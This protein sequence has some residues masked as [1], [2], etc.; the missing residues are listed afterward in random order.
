MK[1][2]SQIAEKAKEALDTEVEPAIK[3]PEK[4]ADKLP[5]RIAE[6]SEKAIGLF[7]GGFM[8]MGL[9]VGGVIGFAASGGSEH[10]FTGGW[11]D[12]VMGVV[13][14]G[15]FGL[16]GGEIMNAVIIMNNKR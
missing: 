6:L 13:L 14:G 8:F 10:F 11:L 5:E 1:D 15:L 7:Y 16:G 4:I 2:I 12:T 3:I 9:A